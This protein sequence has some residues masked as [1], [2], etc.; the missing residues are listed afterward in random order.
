MIE[1]QEDQDRIDTL[2]K[3]AETATLNYVELLEL[4]R[5]KSTL[6]HSAYDIL[7]AMGESAFNNNVPKHMCPYYAG[8]PAWDAWNSGFISEANHV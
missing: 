6:S 2:K 3:K 5:I 1:K 7:F 8:T 4:S